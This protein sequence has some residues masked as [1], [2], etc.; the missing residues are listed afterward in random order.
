LENYEL[1]AGVR[2]AMDEVIAWIRLHQVRLIGAAALLVVGLVMAALLRGLVSR[3]IQ[4]LRRVLPERL[5]SRTLR[6][7]RLEREVGDLLGLVVF[8]AVLFFFLAAAAN[9]LGVPVLAPLLV[10]AGAWLPRLLAAALLLLA[11]IVIGNLARDAATAAAA[12]AGSP[13]APAIG[14]MVRMAILIAAVLVAIA[15]LGVDITLLTALL[16][17]TLLAVLGAFSI[18]F[19]FGARDAVSNIIGAHYAR[20]T[21]EIGRKIRVGEIE[22]TIAEITATS[23]VVQSAAGQVVIPAKL[24]HE[25]VAVLPTTGGEG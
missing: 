8:W 1:V 19:G 2:A 13:F 7:P 24:F 25:T 21:F 5:L 11:G 10:A 20:R 9:L 3:L 6:R 23:V 22:G 17:V 4:A 16:A 15:E 14:Q 12:A 18:A